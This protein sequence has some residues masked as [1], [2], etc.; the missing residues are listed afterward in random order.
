MAALEVKKAEFE[1]EVLKSEVPVL[2]DFWA[3]WC[4]PCKMFSPTIE[5]IADEYEGKVKVCKVNIDEEPQIA[6]TYKIMSIPT[7]VLF[8]GGEAVKSSAGVINKQ[9]VEEFIKE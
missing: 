5:Q 3:S 2:V 6:E 7:I 8:K 1:Q 9:K 4:G